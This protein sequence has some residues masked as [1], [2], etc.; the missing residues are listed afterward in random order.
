MTKFKFVFFTEII[1]QILYL[2]L[3]YTHLTWGL[4]GKMSSYT[5]YKLQHRTRVMTRYGREVCYTLEL[6]QTLHAQ[7]DQEN[8]VDFY[9][10]VFSGEA[11]MCLGFM[12]FRVHP[13]ALNQKKQHSSPNMQPIITLF[14]VLYNFMKRH[15][16][17]IFSK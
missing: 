2:F 15:N 11:K 16:L 10:S 12:S 4:A 6:I 14:Q 8:C 5:A 1:G 3:N 13:V 7:N 17:I 9:N